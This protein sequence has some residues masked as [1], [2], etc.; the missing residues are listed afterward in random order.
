MGNNINNNKENEEMI[1]FEIDTLKKRLSE[2]KEH[3][4]TLQIEI[5]KTNKEKN[6]LKELNES[7]TKR[8][9]ENIEKMR[10]KL[11]KLPNEDEYILLKEKVTILQQQF[12]N[13]ND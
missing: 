10:I 5:D 6:K 8:L 2:S 13:N 7:N 11:Q 4:N 1:H 9:Q 12:L 3:C